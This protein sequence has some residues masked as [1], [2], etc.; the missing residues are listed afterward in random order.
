MTKQGFG[1]VENTSE[2]MENHYF[3]ETNIQ[4]FKSLIKSSTFFVDYATYL[5]QKDRGSFLTSNFTDVSDCLRSTFF[6]L[7]LLDLPKTAE[8]KHEFIPD[9]R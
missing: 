1:S 8:K 3:E 9:E 5:L 7:V 4:K 2:Y 6:A